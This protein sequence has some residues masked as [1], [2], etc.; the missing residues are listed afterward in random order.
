[1]KKICGMLI[2]IMMWFMQSNVFSFTQSIGGSPSDKAVSFNGQVKGVSQP[3]L[4]SVETDRLTGPKDDYKDPLMP[5][6]S[7]GEKEK[8]YA[9]SARG[10]MPESLYETEGNLIKLS[11]V[12]D[13]ED[14]VFENEDDLLL[15]V[16]EEAI[17]DPLEPINRFFFHFN[18]KLYFWFLKP[19]ATGYKAITPQPAR[20]GV[21]NFFYNLAF[22][23]RFVNCLF[24]GKFEGASN[25]FARFVVNTTVG[26]G[27]LLD[28]STKKLNIK[29]YEEDLGQ[30]FGSYGI[31]PGA[32]I[33]WPILGPSSLR[34]TVGLVGDLFL[35]PVN[36]IVPRTKY[37]AS[38][39]TYSG[40]NQTS[41]SIGDYE[42]LKEA[43]LDPY[44]AVRN[45]YFQNRQSK[46]KK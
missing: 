24:Q 43:A 40:I 22:P 39:K 46:I 31:G 18:D 17:D 21:K 3:E 13:S 42:D 11:R 28:V 34:D 45:A 7:F 5:S 35:D 9:D 16:S 25:E 30:T 37:N 23:I 6:L 44:I 4:I 27:G 15:G 41:L 12:E 36:Y 14:T 20:V 1:M 32:Y 8:V 10:S 38:V 2:F 26:V 33:N 19:V 29:R